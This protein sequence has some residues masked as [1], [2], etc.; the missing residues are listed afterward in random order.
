MDTEFVRNCR[1]TCGRRPKKK[2]EGETSALFIDT[3]ILFSE[4]KAY[5]IVTNAIGSLESDDLVLPSGQS[6]LIF[7]DE[8][9][10]AISLTQTLASKGNSVTLLR[11]DAG[12]QVYAELSGVLGHGGVA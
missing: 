2:V 10:L 8:C 3:P 6:F 12:T 5:D 4:A 9:G 11:P 7:D 1:S